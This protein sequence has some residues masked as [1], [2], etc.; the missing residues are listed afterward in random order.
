MPLKPIF[1]DLAW[2]YIEYPGRGDVGI[3]GVTG[4]VVEEAKG[5]VEGVVE[6]AQGVVGGV[7]EQVARVAVGAERE[8]AQKQQEQQQQGKKRGW[9]GFGRS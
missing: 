6:K 2:N 1:L 9:F 7:V 5:V 8:E 3:G 4:G